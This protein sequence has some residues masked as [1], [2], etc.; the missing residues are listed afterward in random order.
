MA[1]LV[2]APEGLAAF[3]A[4]SA[5]RL[6]RSVNICLGPALATIGLTVPTVLAIGLIAN[7]HVILGS[8][9]PRWCS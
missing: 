4:A 7:E 3:R 1:L 8:T 5:N 6:Q 2:L 9:A